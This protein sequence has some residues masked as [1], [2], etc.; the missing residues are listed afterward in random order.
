M[1]PHLTIGAS[2]SANN[3]QIHLE[4][5][6]QRVTKSHDVMGLVGKVFLK[7]CKQCHLKLEAGKV[8][9][10]T[11]TVHCVSFLLPLHLF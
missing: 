8:S 11:H 10:V 5:V 1:T 9:I 4:D 7:V 3:D 2:A 6:A